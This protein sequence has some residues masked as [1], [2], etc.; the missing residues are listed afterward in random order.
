MLRSLHPAVFNF[1]HHN[2]CHKN[3]IVFFLHYFSL[4]ASATQKVEEISMAS[5]AGIE[6][7]I[8]TDK[9]S[10]SNFIE[11]TVILMVN[12]FVMV[13]ILFFSENNSKYYKE[14]LE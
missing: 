3:V 12:G 14:A 9:V 11:S 13:I 4:E 1:F 10:F 6:H 8:N 2:F 5:R 7:A